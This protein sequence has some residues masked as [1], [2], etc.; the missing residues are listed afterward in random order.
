MDDG[1]MFF[2]DAELL[3]QATILAQTVVS[4]RTAQSKSLP[5]DFAGESPEWEVAALEFAQDVERVLAAGS[6]QNQ[7]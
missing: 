3:A 2:C 5:R 6:D 1:A 7:Y 4:I